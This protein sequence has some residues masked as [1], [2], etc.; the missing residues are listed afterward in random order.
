ML[1]VVFNPKTNTFR[2]ESISAN[3]Y[4]TT[5]RQLQSTLK[6]G[7]QT[8]IEEIKSHSLQITE[9]N[10]RL[11]ELCEEL[12]L[13]WTFRVAHAVMSPDYCS[14]F[15][16]EI[17]DANS[18]FIF[19]EAIVNKFFKYRRTNP[20]RAETIS[21]FSLLQMNPKFNDYFSEAINTTSSMND[22]AVKIDT[23][24]RE[25]FSARQVI[26]F[27]KPK[28]VLKNAI[29]KQIES[30]GIEDNKVFSTFIEKNPDF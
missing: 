11:Y 17:A 30:D 12:Q 7:N 29:I 22:Y 3:K 14:D 13:N 28:S 24:V 23:E 10:N 1:H 5:Q 27:W 26:S 8:F 2:L 25:F 20:S 21:K 9:K 16:P 6:I 19:S 15:K 4:P 18:K